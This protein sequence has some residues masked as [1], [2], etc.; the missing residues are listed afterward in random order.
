MQNVR[1][2]LRA[3]EIDSPAP[4][5]HYLR[6]FGQSDREVIQNANTDASV[7]QT[8]VLMNSQLLPQVMNKYS[9]L[10]LSLNKQQYHDEKVTTAYMTLL[11]RQPTEQER[12]I[13]RKAADRG[14]TEMEDLL[15]ALINTQQFIFIQ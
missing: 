13:W 7:A 6:E 10:M 11:S 12:E 9:A 8:L 2:W 14:L 15:Y 5:G 4:R 3:A 1:T